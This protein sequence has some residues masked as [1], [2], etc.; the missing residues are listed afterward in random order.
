MML[1]AQVR[2]HL[3]DVD[4]AGDNTFIMLI[5]QVRQHLMMLIAHVRKYLYGV[6]CSGK[7]TP[8]GQSQGLHAC[9]R[10]DMHIHI[11]IM[12]FYCHIQRALHD[13]LECSLALTHIVP[14][15]I[16]K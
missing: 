5:A 10:V 8:L 4:C 9:I 13:E 14:I 7:T 3:Y 2:Q 16:I 1:I 11:I 12:K 15:Y 6:D